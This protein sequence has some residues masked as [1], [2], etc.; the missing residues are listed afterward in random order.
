MRRLSYFPYIQ[1]AVL[2]LF[3]AIAYFALM[4]IKRA[5]QNKVW[6]GLSKE[7]AHQ[8]GTPISSLMAWTQVL[9][10]NYPDDE[11]LPDGEAG[12]HG[13]RNLRPHAGDGRDELEHLALAVNP[14]GGE[15][16]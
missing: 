2:A 3:F 1:L 13:E 15:A 5:E 16:E 6:V 10:E 7:T 11:L 8:L 4:S 12:E 9:R 14:A